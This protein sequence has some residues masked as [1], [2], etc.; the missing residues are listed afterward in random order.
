M[1]P[2][3]EVIDP[4]NDDDFDTWEYGTEPV[5]GDH[6]WHTHS[7]ATDHE[8]I[9]PCPGAVPLSFEEAQLASVGCFK[10]HQDG[11]NLSVCWEQKIMHTGGRYTYTKW[12]VPLGQMRWTN[13]GFKL[14]SPQPG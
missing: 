7:V 13:H 10:M 1:E 3:H 14:Y 9:P 12:W 6:T 4:R 8:P 2:V 11:S 5:P